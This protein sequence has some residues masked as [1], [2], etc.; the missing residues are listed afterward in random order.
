MRMNITSVA[1]MWLLAAQL[2]QADDPINVSKTGTVLSDEVLYSIGGGSAV[3]MGSAG[4][5]DSIGVGFGWNNDMMCGNMNL[6]T[7]LEN[8]LNGATQ[9]FQ[10][11][12]G[13]VIQNA[14]GAV[15]SLPPE[16]VYPEAL[17]PGLREVGGIFSG[18][19][20]GNLYP[21]SGFLHQTDD[22]KTAAVIAQ[23][24]GDITTRIGQLHVYLPMRAAP[25]DGYW[26]AGELREGDASTGKWQELTP[27]LSLNCAVFPN[28][29][30]KTQAVDGDYAWALWR[31]YSCCQRKGQIF[32]G[33]TDFQ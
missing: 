16:Q 32:L 12:M 27:S 33:S 26:P 5:M 8:Q 25:K 15:M 23:R 13:S 29:G 14:T 1:L 11:I 2:A 28:S 22:Y 4:Q 31:P 19:M 9:G 6:S 18:D 10:N 3:S 21:R 20:W 17:I 24:A 30:P 7:T